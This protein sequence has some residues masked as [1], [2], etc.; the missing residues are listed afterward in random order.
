MI[1]TLSTST[2]L[3]LFFYFKNYFVFKNQSVVDL[4][5][6][7]NFCCTVQWPSHT[8]THILFLITVFHHVLSQEKLGK[9]MVKGFEYMFLPRRYANG[10]KAHEK[11]LK[12][13]QPLGNCKS[14]YNETAFHAHQNGFLKSQTRRVLLRMNRSR[15]PHTLLVEV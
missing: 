5:C 4:Q 2:Y 6:C 9:K 14:K 3:F 13:H 15:K 1:S 7:V 8:Y 12:N 10:Q 11:M